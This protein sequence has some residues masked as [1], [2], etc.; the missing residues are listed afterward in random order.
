MNAWL[1]TIVISCAGLPSAPVR[2]DAVELRDALGARWSPSELR[3]NR[4]LVVVF[5]GVDCPLAKLYAE[6]LA[7]LAER[8]GPQGVG[9][10]AIDPNPQ[11]SQFDLTRFEQLHHLGFSLLSDPQGIAA[12]LL[13]ATRTPEVFVL[14]RDHCVC[15]QGRI[16]DQYTINGR[17]PAPTRHD[18]AEALTEL[19]AGGP[20]SVPQTVATGCAIASR[21]RPETSAAGITYARHIAPILQKHCVA[22][23]RSGQV[24][25]FELTSFEQARDWAATIREVVATRRMPPWHADPRYGR[26][27]ND[28][29][30]SEQERAQ[31]EAWTRAGC[32]AG[33]LAEQPPPATFPEG[34]A[35]GQ[36]DVVISMPQTFRVPATGVIEYQLIELDPGFKTDTWVSAAEIQPGNRAVVHH[37][38]VFLKPPGG[39][40]VTESGTLGSLCL[41]ATAPGTP[42]LVLPPGMAKLVPAGWKFV[43]VIHYAAIGS[44]Q[45]DRTSIG[46][47]LVDGSAVKREVATR[48][49]LDQKLSIPP[50]VADHRVEQGCHVPSDVLL[51]SMFPHLHARG[52]S[53]RYEA[54]YPD[55][56]QEIL[57]D[58]PQYDVNWQ[59]RYDLAEPK[60]LPAGTLV[61]CTAH[62]D[63]SPGN[64][65]NPDPTKLVHTGPQSWDEM[66]NG[67]FDV[68]EA[69]QSGPPVTAGPR[70]R[71]A[72]LTCMGIMLVGLVL[73]LRQPKA[74][75]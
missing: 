24:A 30:L 33:D 48:L 62:Y 7:A 73:H 46:L 34:W 49:I 58:V 26:F 44:E 75:E 15:Y 50:G 14:D 25:P 52:K 17:K 59:N 54:I 60:R 32:P 4:G 29:S 42:A 70:F 63:N 13:G 16:D 18:L 9:F 6:R 36:P 71:L 66:F 38:T 64:P 10:I 28:P 53:F 8:F 55:G 19:L 20:V 31:I 39:S 51:L 21:N 57:L 56:T 65:R 61:R 1:F 22:C 11:D 3:E 41:V 40:E 23:H 35:I 45:T 69:E 47:R 67:Y 74:N 2:L 37:A 68:V 5:L 12:P 72:M 27:A 43:L